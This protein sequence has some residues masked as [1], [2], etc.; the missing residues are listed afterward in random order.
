MTIAAVLG[1]VILV[2][3]QPQ[4]SP[5]PYSKVHE[6]F[7]RNCTGCH[8]RA[9]QKGGLILEHYKGVLNGGDTGLVVVP[10]KPAE[11][12]LLDLVEQRKKPVMPP[13]KK[14]EKLGPAE[15]ALLRAWIAAGAP[16]PKP[17]EVLLSPN[18][19]APRIA[20]RV[21][22]RR[23]VTAAAYEPGARL[24]ALARHAEIE[25]R[26]AEHR[27]IV[28]TLS[29]HAGAVG[30]VAFSAD[31]AMLAAA[32]GEPGVAGEVLLWSVREGGLLRA[33]RGH[34]DAVTAVAISPDGRLVA[35]GSYD[36]SIVLWDASTGAPL[37]ELAGHNEAVFDLA[38]RP[39]GRILAS[40]SADR[41]VKLWDVATGERRDTL[42]EPTKALHAVA[43]SPD[44]RLVAA[45]GA[46]N[47]VRTWEVSAEARE[48]TNAIRVSRF[49]HEGA[50]LRLR[51]STDGKT[52]LTSADDRTVKIW[53]AAD[54]SPRLVLETQPDWPSALTFALGDSAV[55]VGRLDGSFAVYEAA[56]GKQAAAPKPEPASLEPRGLQRGTTARIVLTGKNLA[57]ATAVKLSHPK[58][59][60]RLEDG[61]RADTAA[62]SVAAAPDLPPGTYEI[63]L[64]G[65]GGEG[66]RLK[67]HVDDLPQV[68]EAEPND[69]TDRSPAAPLPASFWGRVSKPGDL[70]HFAFEARAGQTIV[71]DAAARRMGS[72]ADLA[73]AL[74]DPSGR[75]VASNSDF[76]DEAD[77]LL[78]Y[79]VPADGRY[80]ARVAD[81]QLG[82][83]ND[84]FYRLSVGAL[85]VVTSC[86]PLTVPANAETEVR[87][88]G[89]N[90]P[91]AAFVRVKA[92]A[93]GELAVPID[94]ARFRA[95]REF[96]VLVTE[97]PEPVEEEP[98]DRPAQARPVAGGANGRIDRPG[99][100]DLFRFEA[101]AGRTLVIETAAAR[102]AS[103]LDTRIEVLH[104]D[105]RPVERVLLRA[106]RDSWITFRPIDANAGGARLANWEEMD[107]NQL[108]YLNGEVVKLFLAPRGPDSEYNFYALGG[109][110][111]C[112]FDTSATAHAL[113]EACYVVEPH[114]PGAKLPPSG[115]PVFP[116]PYANDDDALRKLG[117][118]SRLHFAAPADGP[119]LVRVTD[120]RGAGG[121]R[122]AYRLVVRE[123][124]PDFRVTLEG[125]NPAVPAGAGLAFTARVDRID[126]FEGPVEVEITGVPPGFTVSSPLVIEAGHHEAKGTI[127]AAPDAAKPSGAAPK[128][129]ASATVD[130]RRVTREAGTL[131]T[132]TL[133]PRPKVAVSLAPDRGGAGE[134]A[135][136]PGRLTP[137]RLR[138]ERNGFS[139]RVTFTVENLPHGVI[140]ADIGLS[141]VL[142]PEGQD[143]R[144]IF[145]QCA[146]WVRPTARLCHARAN[147]AGNP[148]SPPVTL[149]VAANP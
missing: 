83:S 131:G 44:G 135:V 121:D 36:R 76:G 136:Q 95:R 68:S 39:D 2:R 138:I 19:T 90:L 113:D 124:R 115:L 49:A 35:S 149:R 80:V 78:A 92:G 103:P 133:A 27:A 46:D 74:F 38:F 145:L 125:V 67:L 32:G 23:S 33:L 59:E 141:G 112:Y 89:F 10:G 61:A 93:P 30:A 87:L 13:P 4:D 130:G 108:V 3:V 100:V 111:A 8:N 128:A 22:P 54:V 24:L 34:G 106:V 40:A 109:K 126:G 57:G 47:R 140:V 16:G 11:S 21:P 69:A 102:R 96:S 71:L 114:A 64:A 120:A 6:I 139:E 45:A 147:E 142:I 42:S 97:G 122:H 104:P 60:G 25:L 51:W 48:G 18:L 65:E 91:A 43:W 28:R 26:S 81:L 29:G 146:P 63:W 110:R 12:L 37:Q 5:P 73:L 129:S 1:L 148:T 144:R 15:I 116:L 77:P 107:L 17:G 94:P 134:I 85:P 127:H 31:G 123:A 9:E 84:H 118:D 41:T 72:K 98:N 82:G 79:R 58:L 117:T 62:V 56:S 132:I 88:A 105:G 70:D 55:V 52:L 119:Y 143:E 53:D 99:D 86:F 75:M 20:P 137:A 14:G 50:I 66:P 7:V 101:A